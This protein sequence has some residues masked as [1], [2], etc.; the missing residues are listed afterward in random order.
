ML[1][2]MEGTIM[3]WVS[4]IS[5]NTYIWGFEAFMRRHFTNWA[6]RSW[7]LSLNF[8]VR[9]FIWKRNHY[10]I[11]KRRERIAYNR[12]SLPSKIGI[13]SSTAVRW[14]VTESTV[15]GSNPFWSEIFRIFHDRPWGPPSVL[16]I[17]HRVIPGG[18]RPGA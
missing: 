3:K 10:T 1:E 17:G 18:K 11:S 12:V 16:Y 2:E 6:N 15:R 4:T 5:V 7:M 9:D 14:L 13:F 8:I